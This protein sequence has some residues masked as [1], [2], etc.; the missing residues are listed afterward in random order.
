MVGA[1]SSPYVYSHL[2]SYFALYPGLQPTGTWPWPQLRQF[3]QNGLETTGTAGGVSGVAY[4]AGWGEEQDLDVQTVATVRPH[5]FPMEPFGTSWAR[6]PLLTP[7]AP[8][9]SAL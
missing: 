9:R 6:V 1:Y 4:N 3:N 7:R 8:V 2:A 5:F